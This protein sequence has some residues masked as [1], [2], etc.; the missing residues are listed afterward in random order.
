MIIQCV[1]LHNRVCNER[2]VRGNEQAKNI[3]QTFWVKFGKTFRKLFTSP[4]NYWLTLRDWFFHMYTDWLIKQSERSKKKF[5]FYF[6]V[7]FPPHQCYMV[8]EGEHNI[9]ICKTLW[10]LRKLFTFSCSRSV[11]HLQN[12]VFMAQSHSQQMNS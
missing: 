5:H 7:V 1:D 10:E 2:T 6:D 11:H 12:S 9:L 4:L 3:Q 8:Y